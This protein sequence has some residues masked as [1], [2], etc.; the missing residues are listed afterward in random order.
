MAASSS[1]SES[2]R[3][4]GTSSSTGVVEE[5]VEEVLARC[6][7]RRR[8]LRPGQRTRPALLGIHP[9]LISQAFGD[10]QS[11]VEMVLVIIPVTEAHQYAV[12]IEVCAPE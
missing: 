10:L 2:P 9:P 12:Q 6:G 5:D 8:L 7:G 3:V 4:V 11:L 1:R